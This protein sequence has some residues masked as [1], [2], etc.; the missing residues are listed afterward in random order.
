M[1]RFHRLALLVAALAVFGAASA[2]AGGAKQDICHFPPGNPANFH[3]LTVSGN[4]VNAHLTNHNDL[5]GSCLANC[6]TICDDGNACTIDVVANPDQCICASEPRAQVDCSDGNSCTADS[7][8]AGTGSCVNDPAPVNGNVCDDDNSNTNGEACF[9]SSCDPPCP[10][11]TGGSIVANGAVAVCGSNFPGF[12]NLTGMIWTNGAR[13]C[14]GERCAGPGL[15]C[16][17]TNP[18][19]VQPVT[20]Q[21]DQNCRAL[22]LNYCS[23]PNLTQGLASG[24]ESSTLFID[25]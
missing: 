9:N 5:L 7:C 19:H 10:C 23:T 16:L 15:T 1:K 8:N 24:A 13:A 3:T 22:L 25:N 6:E 21:E 18:F 20:V 2:Q 12:P 11:F 4:A 14:S 17:N